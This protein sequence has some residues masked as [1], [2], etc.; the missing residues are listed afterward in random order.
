LQRSPQHVAEFL[1]ATATDVELGSL[2]GTARLDIETLLAERPRNV[3]PLDRY[4][5][6]GDARKGSPPAGGHLT[7]ENPFDREFRVPGRA[8]LY[9]VTAAAT[10]VLM[11]ATLFALR[12]DAYRTEVGEQRS[13][14][15]ADGSLVELNTRSR[16]KVELSETARVIKL[17]EGEALFTVARDEQRPFEVRTGDVTIRAI[18]TQFNVYRH[19]R[20][21]TVTVVEGRVKI[22]APSAEPL[23]LDAGQ[24]AAVNADGRVLKAS[25]PQVKQALAWQQR[26]LEFRSATVA[27]A[28][29]EFNRYNRLQIHVAD[30][31]IGQRRMS[32]LFNA[33]EPQSLLDFLAS[34][35]G[36]GFDRTADT[37]SLHALPN[38]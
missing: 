4:T 28:A 1:L 22:A 35:G 18:G 20:G 5:G 6:E 7:R 23:L 12:P 32:G 33:D 36:V 3:V 9:I 24:E 19:E 37:V 11:L 30:E 27:E 2:E 16:I 15:L 31:S 34:E 21:A 29:S 17:L 14:K 8:R 25:A 10:A 13:V 38:P 26:R